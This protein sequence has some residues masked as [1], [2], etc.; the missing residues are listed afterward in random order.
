MSWALL[1][2]ADDPARD[3][4]HQPYTAHS[5]GWDAR[6]TGVSRLSNPYSIGSREWRWWDDGWAHGID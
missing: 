6:D 5:Q 4:V 3:L 2:L 1:P